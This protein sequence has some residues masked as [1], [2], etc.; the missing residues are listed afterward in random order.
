[1]NYVDPE[2][3]TF[4]EGRFLV[5][6]A[7]KAVSTY[8]VRKELLTPPNEAPL[9]LKSPGAS[10]V[11]ILL[12]TEGGKEELRGCIGYTRPIEPLIQNVIHAAI[13]AATQDPRFPP[14][15]LY[16]LRNSII[17]VSILSP[18]ESL[19]GFGK[20]LLKQFLIGRDGLV[21]EEGFYTGLLLPEVPVEYCWDEETFLSETCVKAGL[22]PA[23]WLRE[24]VNVYRFRSKAFK[25]RRP[26]GEIYVRKLHEEYLSKC[27]H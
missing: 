15:K 7:R 23:C 22:D 24:S 26:G 3:V 21:V 5:K 19:K 17:E 12:L 8:I 14:M 25:E 18:P 6:L 11:T 13:A 27:S 16:E 2:E 20:P 4:E 10:F 9:K 1:M